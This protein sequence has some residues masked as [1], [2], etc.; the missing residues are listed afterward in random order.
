MGNVIYRGEIMAIY[1][2]NLS[3]TSPIPT[4]LGFLRAANQRGLLKTTKEQRLYNNLDRGAQG[5]QY[6][7]NMLE[8]YGRK[9]WVI[10]E[11]VW[12]DYYGYMKV[13]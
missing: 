6:V 4:Q 10:V 3:K 2:T 1:Q 8:I 7:K 13:I 12:L 9:H 11:N 5:E